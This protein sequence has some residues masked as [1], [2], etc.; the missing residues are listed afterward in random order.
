M[1][2]STEETEQIWYISYEILM[3]DILFGVG[4]RSEAF[5]HF[6]N[7]FP[8]NPTVDIIV[9]DGLAHCGSGG[10]MKGAQQPRHGSFRSPGTLPLQVQD[11]CHI[12][13]LQV[14]QGGGN[15][16]G[17]KAEPLRW[18]GAGKVNL[19]SKYRNVG[20][21]S[22]CPI[23]GQTVLESWSLVTELFHLQFYPENRRA[24]LFTET[25]FLADLYCLSFPVF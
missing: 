24:C 11:N 18:R 4:E 23:M 9:L 17:R 10:M 7:S 6:C 5:I 2:N 22:V 15:L 25:K 19:V 21:D 20:T 14:R 16:K 13:K 3:R 8:C 1:Q 12:R